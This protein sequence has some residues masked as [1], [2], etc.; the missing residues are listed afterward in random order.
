MAKRNIERLTRLIN[1][2][3]DFQT[4]AGKM[5][6]DMQQRALDRVVEEVLN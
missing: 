4:D 2:V 1:D 5:T 3:L 6:F